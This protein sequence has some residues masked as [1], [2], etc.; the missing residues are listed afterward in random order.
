MA[1]Q[2]GGQLA[3]QA[4]DA[5][6]KLGRPRLLL[7]QHAVIRGLQGGRKAVVELDPQ[8]FTRRDGYQASE[9]NSAALIAR[10]G[11]AVEARSRKQL[12][13]VRDV[14]PEVVATVGGRIGPGS[15]VDRRFLRVTVACPTSRPSAWRSRSY[16]SPCCT[17][18]LI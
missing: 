6:R 16:C 2:L 3:T 10:L 18:R 14:D 7:E 13:A 11:L 1:V 8:L 9:R 4:V 12:A 17:S 5:D 15:V